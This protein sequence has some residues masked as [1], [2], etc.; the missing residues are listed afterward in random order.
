MIN[1][2]FYRRKFVIA[3][4]AIGVVL[5][6]MVRLF[7]LQVIDK[8]GREKS[9]NI[10]LVHQTIF[11]SRGLI[12]D[13]N[14]ELLV[15][16]Q[17]IYEVTMIMR[18]MGQ[19]F[20]TI[21][22]CNV[23]EIDKHF[24]DQRIKDIKNKRKNRGYSPYSPQVFMNGLSQADIAPL[25]EEMYKFAG[26]DIRSRTLRA[27]T[28]PVGAHVLGSVGEV[29]QRDIEKDEYYTAGDYAGRDGIERT[30]E[31]DLRGEKGVH[32]LLRDAKGRI[33]G[34]YQNGELDKPAL[35]GADLNVTLDIH[36]QAVAEQLLQ[37][38]IGSIVAIEP[39]TGEILALASSP[40][41]NPE[42]LV[43]K[44]RSK[45]YVELQKDPTKPLYNRATQ[46]LY[47]PG[48]TFKT[49]QALVQLQDK[50]LTPK[51]K[52]S[53]QGPES[54][55]IVCTHDH[56]S[57]VD[58]I[59]AIEQ[60]CNPYFW[61]SF[62]DYLEKDGYGEKNETF[63]S[64]YDLWRENIRSFGLGQAFTD[65]DLSEQKSGS[66]PS[67]ELYNKLY[68]KRG[69]KAITIRSLSIGQG[70][71]LVTPLQLANMTAAIANGGYYITPHLNKHDSMRVRR[72]ETLIDTQYFPLVKKGM[73]Q[74]MTNG[75]GRWYNI[76]SLQIA[77]K[78]GTV[79][80]GKDKKDHALFIG[81]APVDNP[82]IAVAVVIENAG[83]GATWAA[84][85]GTLMIE[86]YLT[87]TIAR[88]QI[89]NQFKNAVTNPDVQSR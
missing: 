19:N 12:Y 89:F 31:K 76:D 79:Q 53:C 17:P 63:K 42:L 85:I 86:Q 41:W 69:W 48:S 68:G 27:Y 30:Y 8:T 20:D 80:N 57:P 34:H 11:P 74:V 65:T 59:E 18:E 64:R 77:G 38:K 35:K 58:L 10:S 13:R 72:H 39:A 82:Q 15:S 73:Q 26:I 14:G 21:A 54:Y 84:P 61:Y 44:E 25:Q 71:I 29:S 5:V 6:F 46:A 45:N 2:K 33:Q 47:A 87:D 67:S 75:T 56:G 83:F 40:T 70:E 78:T 49:V 22:F 4:I 60:S 1:D 66:I 36:L 24:F 7:Y 3:A 88:T 16:N 81:L 52:Y 51:K 55:P 50:V 23:L 62:R 43:G 9:G 32:V 28:Y 37:G